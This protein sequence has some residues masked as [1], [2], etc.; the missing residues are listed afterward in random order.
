MG[1]MVEFFY[2]K[3]RINA[4]QALA[5]SYYKHP[6]SETFGDVIGSM[7]KAGYLSKQI[8]TKRPQ[9]LT[10]TMEADVRLV[11]SAE[12]ALRRYVEMKIDPNKIESRTEVEKAKLNMAASE[13]VLTKLAGEKYNKTPEEQKPDIQINI[14]NYNDG[15]ALEAKSGGQSEVIKEAEVIE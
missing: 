7:R 2:M 3:E 13:F 15:Q 5:I 9:W 10:E 1:F 8:P 11:K 4:R 14:V 12:N 6:K